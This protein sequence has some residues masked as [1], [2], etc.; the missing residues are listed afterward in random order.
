MYLLL[1]LLPHIMVLIPHII[2]P[3]PH[4]TVQISHITV[5]SELNLSVAL[6]YL[7]L[8]FLLVG[9]VGIIVLLSRLY[10]LCLQKYENNKTKDSCNESSGSLPSIITIV[11]VAIMICL[12]LDRL[13]SY[14]YRKMK[15]T[16]QHVLCLQKYKNHRTSAKSNESP[17]T[18][19][20]IITIVVDPIKPV[21][22]LQSAWGLPMSHGPVPVHSY[23]L[24]ND[25]LNF[26]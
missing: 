13:Y 9:V 22:Y 16:R 25:K 20:S 19:P 12:S 3:S 6:T 17:G 8:L 10:C 4:I 18:R 21:H 11:V 23:T 15:T 24:K 7:L 1:Q 2:V 26:I 5:A 14:V